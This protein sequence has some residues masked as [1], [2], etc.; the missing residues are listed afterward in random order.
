[1]IEEKIGGHIA[2]CKINWFN[3]WQLQSEHMKVPGP[4]RYEKHKNVLSMEVLK[5]TE[6]INALK[7]LK[8]GEWY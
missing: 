5:R 4:G 2:M 7:Y 8:M 6:K 3:Q 1:M